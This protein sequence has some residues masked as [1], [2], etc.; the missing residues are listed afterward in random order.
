M[1]SILQAAISFANQY[2]LSTSQPSCTTSQCVKSY[3]KIFEDI[4]SNEIVI[5]KVTDSFSFCLRYSKLLFLNV[6]A[7]Q[8]S[9]F[10]VRSIFKKIN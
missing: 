9:V 2:V 5:T 6:Y 3:K 1:I 10:I 7:V 4:S 8:H